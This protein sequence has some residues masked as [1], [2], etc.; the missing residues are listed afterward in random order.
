MQNRHH[1]RILF[2]SPAVHRKKHL[3][4]LHFRCYTT[5]RLTKQVR[6]VETQ[7]KTPSRYHLLGVSSAFTEQS[8]EAGYRNLLLSVQPFAYVMADY[9]C[10]NGKNPRSKYFHSGNTSFLSQIAPDRSGNDSIIS[11]IPKIS[12]KDT[13]TRY[14]S[15][16]IL[17]IGKSNKYATWKHEAKPLAAATAR[18]FFYLSQRKKPFIHGFEWRA[19]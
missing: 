5:S 6:L 14:V 15:G 13:L 19:F 9:T 12:R 17:Q 2:C 8:T 11:C 16:A 4:L 1:M 18:G 3:D 10:H 7:S